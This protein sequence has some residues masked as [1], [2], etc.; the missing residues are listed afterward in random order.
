LPYQEIKAHLEQ[1]Q[2]ALPARVRSRSL[3]QL[4]SEQEASDAIA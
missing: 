4:H 1:L 3:V 2:A